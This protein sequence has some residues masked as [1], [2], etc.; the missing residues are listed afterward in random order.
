M[1][2]RMNPGGKKYDRSLHLVNVNVVID[3]KYVSQTKT[4]QY[5]QSVPQDAQEQ[6]N[7]VQVTIPKLQLFQRE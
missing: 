5:C 4:S 3:W 7:G 6:K 1:H 2:D